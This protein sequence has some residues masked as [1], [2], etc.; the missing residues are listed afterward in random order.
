MPPEETQDPDVLEAI[1]WFVRLRDEEATD[2]DRRAFEAWLNESPAHQDAWERANRLWDRFSLAGV[3]QAQ[4][5][6]STL[7]RRTLLG[8]AGVA[9]FAAAG[10]GYW[11]THP[12]LGADY[13]TDAGERRTVVLPDGTRVELASLS[14]LSVRFDDT[15]R[16]TLL[17]SG[18]AYFDV[19][20]DAARPFV[21]EAKGGSV[22]ALGT[23]FDVKIAES[24]VVVTVTQHA[25]LI[26][27]GASPPARVEQGFQVNY[28]A[29]GLGPIAKANLDAVEAWR[30]DLLIF[31]ELPLAQ[32]LIELGRYRRGR[33]VLLDRRLGAM[34]VTG[35]FDTRQA[36]AALQT[37]A[38]ALP[39]RLAY[40]TDYV[41]FVHAR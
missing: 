10:G 41:V 25:A 22:Q 23:R 19:A 17:F 24:T 9:V 37:I 30:Q 36:D 8:G 21:V 4:R 40:V 28:D 39:I 31:K 38:E 33:I 16:R 3:A 15:V 20:R 18:E 6:R 14:A 7:S 5:R 32:V 35:V 1:K 29:Q 26:R 34:P 27:F 12:E 2:D 11:L 13:R